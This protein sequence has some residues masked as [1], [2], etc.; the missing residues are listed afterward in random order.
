MY[1]TSKGAIDAFT[2]GF[3]RE[4]GHEGIRVIGVRPGITRT[5]S[6]DS[7]AGGLAEAAEIARRHTVLGRMAEP[8]EIA[9]LV[10]WL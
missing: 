10:L 9:Q 3:A 5:E 4:V 2:L 8:E 6:F 1:A 7:R